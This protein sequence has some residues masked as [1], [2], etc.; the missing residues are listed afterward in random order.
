MDAKR[1]WDP[2]VSQV[3]RLPNE[4]VVSCE[5]PGIMNT[6]HW[7]AQ[8][9]VNY[10]FN[11][12]VEY[13]MPDGQLRLDQGA[14]AVFWGG[15][16]HRVCDTGDYTF[17]HAIHLPL[18][19]FFRLRLGEAI[20][21]RLMA[22]AAFVTRTPQ[23]DDDAA[24]ARRAEGLRSS[25]A[26]RV[27]HS[28]DELLL[29]IERMEFEAPELLGRD[30]ARPCEARSPGQPGFQCIRKICEFIA[31]NFREDIHSSDVALSA[32]IHPKYAMSVFKKS[33]G[34][35]LGEYIT[36]LRLSYAQSLLV[37]EDASILQ[38]A[39][40]SGFGSLSA[41][42]KCFRKKAGMT[43]S[44]FKREQGAQGPMLS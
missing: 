15:M 16:P 8:I 12:F 42:N 28:I 36:L 5:Q 6:A 37:E 13:E 20:Q 10:V 40:D 34:M 18:Y 19:H 24:F 11:G 23:P 41:F 29:R 14:L 39:M 30:L 35:S 27:R 38:I 25:Q 17:F 33:T 1:Y 3:E 4:L 31:A 9:E 32:D 22:G 43:P 21:H 7:H 2:A 26:A 44:E